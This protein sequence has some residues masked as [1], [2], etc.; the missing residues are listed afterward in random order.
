MVPS[1]G[2]PLCCQCADDILLSGKKKCPQCR[3]NVTDDSFKVMKFN[4]DMKV[5]SKDQKLYF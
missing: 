4:T 1:C 3:E 2:H 5:E